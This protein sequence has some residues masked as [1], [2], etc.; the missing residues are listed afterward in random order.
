[1]GALDSWFECAIIH[2]YIFAQSSVAGPALVHDVACETFPPVTP[3]AYVLS[4]TVPRRYP[5]ARQ[6][7]RCDFEA[8][9]ADPEGAGAY[10]SVPIS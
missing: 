8:G 5:G 3:R 10:R 6:S 2:L 4:S 9:Q 1:M 7:R